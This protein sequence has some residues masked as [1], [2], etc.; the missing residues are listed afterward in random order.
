MG[1][2]LFAGGVVAAAVLAAAGALGSTGGA[3]VGRPAGGPAAALTGNGC[4]G[5]GDPWMCVLAVKV[6]SGGSVKSSDKNI[7]CVGPADEASP[8]CSHTYSFTGLSGPSVSLIESANSGWTFSGWNGDCAYAGTSPEC[9]VD[10]SDAHSVSAS[11]A[12]APPP[13]P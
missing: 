10:M 5:K 1:G 12:Q 7:D 6:S 11:F 4:T 9:K 13:P 2:R 8:G 3:V